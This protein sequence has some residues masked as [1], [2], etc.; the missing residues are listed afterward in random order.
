MPT[1]SYLIEGHLIVG[2][3]MM[4]V[5]F[6][7]VALNIVDGDMTREKAQKFYAGFFGILLWPLSIVLFVVYGIGR[8]LWYTFGPVPSKEN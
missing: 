5:L 3:L 8:S 4:V 7:I 6:I 1:V 2:G